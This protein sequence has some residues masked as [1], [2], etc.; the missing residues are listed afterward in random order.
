MLRRTYGFTDLTPAAKATFRSWLGPIALKSIDG[1]SVVT[2]LMEEMRKR[3]IIIPGV[4]VIERMAA[5][6]MH[7]A[8]QSVV[9][10]VLGQVTQAQMRAIDALLTEKANGLQSRFRWLQEPAGKI[11]ARS[12]GEIMDRLDAAR[13]IGLGTLDL[14]AA[15]AERL[16]QMAREGVRFTA[17]ALQQMSAARRC[18]VMVATLRDIEIGLV[19]A[20]L[21][22]FESVI[23]R[24]YNNAKSRLEE[25]RANH[26]DDVKARLHRVADVLDAMIAAHTAS[27]DIAA[28]VLTV[29]PLETIRADAREL[30][31][32]TRKGASEVLAELEPEHRTLKQIGPRLL[33]AFTFEGR[34]SVSSLL[35][36]IA[37]LK[38][39]A[40]DPRKAVPP[41]APTD[42]I[43]PAWRRYVFRKDG[44]DR[45]YYELAILLRLGLGAP[46]GRRV[47][48]GLKIAPFNRDLPDVADQHSCRARSPADT[49]DAD[50]RR[51]SG[52][53]NAVARRAAPRNGAK[54]RAR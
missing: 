38:D 33:N 29:A 50:R 24:A 17:Q 36:A 19:D 40:Q 13:A 14:P 7:A 20:A 27:K 4:S 34:A 15:F 31:Q 35:E 44:T 47:G 16:A 54:A 6:A 11:G 2:A 18:T 5:Q 3:R 37:V 1:L 52:R 10:Q 25:A 49:A 28:A 30:R 22:M 21:T 53:S 8:D 43:E 26:S 45:R 51:L 48:L 39:L 9:K 23:G 42:F 41:T 12:F 46:V 32:S